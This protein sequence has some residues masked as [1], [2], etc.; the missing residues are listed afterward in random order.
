MLSESEWV[1]IEP[2]LRLMVNQTQRHREQTGANLEAA[3]ARGYEWP[4][5]AKHKELTGRDASDA[6][7]IWNHR[8]SEHGSPCVGCGRL[9]QTSSAKE[10]YNCGTLVA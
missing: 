2:L 6:H 8:L 1:Q 4:V 10:C 7:C 5:L 3:L 9:L